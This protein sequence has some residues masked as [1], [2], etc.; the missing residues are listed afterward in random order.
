MSILDRHLRRQG[1]AQRRHARVMRAFD[2]GRLDV[3][4][5]RELTPFYGKRKYDAAYRA[6]VAEQLKE[7]FDGPSDT[8]EC[9]DCQGSGEGSSSCCDDLCQD[10][11]EGDVCMHGDG[12]EPCRECGGKGWLSAGPVGDDT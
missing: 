6:G 8:V 1:R 5:G 4:Y 2:E 3:I 10:I 9:W 12:N 11:E 7:E